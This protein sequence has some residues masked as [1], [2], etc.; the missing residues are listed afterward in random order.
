MTIYIYLLFSLGV[1]GNFNIKFYKF[2]VWRSYLNF[3]DEA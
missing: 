3:F 1:N 2:E